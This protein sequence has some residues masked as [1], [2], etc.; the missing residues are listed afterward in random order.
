LSANN[1]KYADSDGTITPAFGPLEE[2]FSKLS[3]TLSDDR[4]HFADVQ[5]DGMVDLVQINDLAWGFFSR[6]P[7]PDLGWN[8]FKEFKSFPN[9]HVDQR[10]KFVDL[11][12]DGLP[13]IL[14][15]EDHAFVCYPSLGEEGYGEPTRTI[16]ALDEEK[17]PRLLFGD[18]EQAIHL[19]DMSGDG[20]VD[21][22]TCT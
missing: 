1:T 21:F 17:G 8:P 19:A 15:S 11:T 12:G 18:V 7:K 14:V 22:A 20:L 4:S 16:Q 10:S 2:V 9:I 3:I 6:R 13:D 5:G